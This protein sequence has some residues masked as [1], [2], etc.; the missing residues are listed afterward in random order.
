MLKEPPPYHPLTKWQRF[1]LAPSMSFACNHLWLVEIK[2]AI[3]GDSLHCFHVHMCY[4][5]SWFFL[6]WPF[7]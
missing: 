2:I 3:Q 5:I 4:I 7:L 6:N 1:W